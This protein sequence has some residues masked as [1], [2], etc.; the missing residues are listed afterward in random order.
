M[1]YN[2]DD[3]VNYDFWYTSSSDRALN[4]LE[5]FRVMEDKL[6]GLA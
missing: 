2:E 6:H 3:K 4:F 1:S 5:D